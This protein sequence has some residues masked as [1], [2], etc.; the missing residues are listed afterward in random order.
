VPAAATLRARETCG[1]CDPQIVV[2]VLVKRID[3][4]GRQSI[5][6]CEGAK[7]SIEKS[8]ETIRRSNPES[9]LSI[10][11]EAANVIRF[12]LRRI[13]FIE[14]RKAD[15][16]KARHASFSGNPNESISCLNDGVDRVLRQSIFCQ[17]NLLPELPRIASRIERARL[18][19]V[20]QRGGE[21]PSDGAEMFDVDGGR[22]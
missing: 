9:T 4:I 14:D 19:C 11:S 16:V 3:D 18:T 7:L 22:H 10:F 21:K 17:P 8:D 13:L 6:F 15:A 12:Q 5:L 20:G 2:A 1:C